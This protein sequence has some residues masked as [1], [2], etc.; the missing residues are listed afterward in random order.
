MLLSE[1]GDAAAPKRPTRARAILGLVF[2]LLAAQPILGCAALQQ[3]F[4]RPAPPVVRYHER[5]RLEAPRAEVVRRLRHDLRATLVHGA[6]GPALAMRPRTNV[7][8]PL[9]MGVEERAGVLHLE[10]AATAE[11]YAEVQQIW[12]RVARTP[13]IGARVDT[14]GQPKERQFARE[15]GLARKPSPR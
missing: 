1:G 7:G 5:F 8:E 4:V 2:A 15:P 14:T 13:G 3:L 9:V 10:V 12:R 6:T 11:R